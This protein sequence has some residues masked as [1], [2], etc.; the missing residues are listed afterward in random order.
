[1]GR[2]SRAASA[3]RGAAALEFAL[4]VPVLALLVFG[5]IDYGLYFTDSLGAR[6]GARVAARQGVVKAFPTDACGDLTTSGDDDLKQLACLAVE[7]SSPV[8]GIA[9]AHITGPATWDRGGDLIV[10]VA[11][12]VTGVTGYVPMPNDHTVR[13]VIHMRIEQPMNKSGAEGDATT[14]DVIPG[15]DFWA[16][17]CS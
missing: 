7:Q 8:G 5:M 4:V 15:G 11:I 12:K 17:W 9:Y 6:D 13:T 16:P 10:C 2:F 14:A 3:D 1:M